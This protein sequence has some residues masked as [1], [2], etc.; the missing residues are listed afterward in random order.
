[1]SYEQ[2]RL[3]AVKQ[4]FWDQTSIDSEGFRVDLGPL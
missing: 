1:M 3:R 4:V 2:V